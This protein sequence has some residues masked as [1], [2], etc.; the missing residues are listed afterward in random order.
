MTC[1]NN[2]TK[3]SEDVCY[4]PQ[5]DFSEVKSRADEEDFFSRDL[6]KKLAF[7]KLYGRHIE[8]ADIKP[9][10]TPEQATE[11]IKEFFTQAF[12]K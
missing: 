12:N 1:K 11:K 4:C 5:Y 6:A 8:L 10:L 7:N 9:P 3:C 2:S